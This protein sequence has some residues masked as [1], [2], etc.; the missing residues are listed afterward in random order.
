MLDTLVYLAHETDVWFEVTTLL[1]PGEN[2]SAEEI[3]AA[4]RWFAK[5]LGPDVPWHFTAF[6]PDYRMLDKQRTPAALLTRAREIALSHGLRYVYTGNVRD[7]TG[8]STMC[9]ACGQKLIGRDAYVLTAWNLTDEG[10]C[11]ACG[12]RCP[13]TFDALPG[14]WGARRQPVRLADFA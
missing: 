12:E 9:H 7:E 2:D 6:H 1:I 11:N 10:C 4:S 13:G 14:S 5:E 8:G 3:E